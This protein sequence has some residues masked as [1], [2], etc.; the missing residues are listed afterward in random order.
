MHLE[1]LSKTN[2]TAEA[3]LSGVLA[4][5]VRARQFSLA[6]GLRIL[7]FCC[8]YALPVLF[9][10]SAD[11]NAQSN[12][13][14]AAINGYVVDQAGNALRGA[15][16]VA[17]NLA[18]GVADETLSDANGYYR[19]PILKIGKY[20]VKV[21]ADGFADLVKSAV[22]LEVGAE[23]RIDAAL[24]VG[25]TSTT[26]EVRPD[27]SILETS[28]PAIGAH[29]D[30]N[31]LRVLPITSRNIYNYEF[32][33]PGVVGY[34]KST[35]SAPHPAYN[36]ITSSTL[37]LDGIDNTQRNA[38]PDIRLVISTPEVV[39]QSQT[40]VNGA[41][42]EFGRTAGGISNIVSRSGGNEYHGQVLA[43]LRPNATRAVNALITGGKPSSKW[44]DYDGNVGGPILRN[45]LFFFANFEYNSLVN[46]DSIAITAADAAVLKIPSSEL[47]YAP[48]SERYP[49][50]SVRVDYKVNE[51]NNAFFRWSYFSNHEPNDVGGGY[52]PANTGQYW[53]DQMQSGEA[54]LTTAVTPT[55]LN[56]FRFGVTRR[57]DGDFNMQS[58]VTKDEVITNIT[59]VA[60]FGANYNGNSPA[61][62]R[63]IAIVDNVTKTVGKHTVKAGVDF[64]NTNVQQ[65]SPLTLA[66]TFADLASYEKTIGGICNC[67]QEAM[68]QAG[69][70][71]I[72]NYWNSPNLFVQDEYRANRKLT[73]NAGLRYQLISWPSLDKSAP[74]KDSRSIYTSHLDFAPRLS[75]SY[76]LTP[77]TTLR[78]AGGL[79]FDTPS[80]S[81]FNDISQNNGANIHT[82]VFT[83]G[84][85]SPTYPNVPTS[86]GLL[87]SS[88]PS[89]ATYDPNYR[90]M[91]AIQ[92]NLQVERAI[93]NNLSV[94]LSYQFLATRHSPYGHD[95][96]LAAPLCRLADGRPAYTES[97]CGTGS[98]TS[99]T[100]PNTN[101]GSIVMVS[102]GAT[103]NYNGLHATIKQRLSRGIQFEATYSWSKT[104]GTADQVNDS[105]GSPIEDPTNIAREYGPQS[106]DMRHNFVLQGFFSP[107]TTIKGL[108]WM[109]NFNLSTMT[110]LHS[111]SPIN[112]YAG[113][114][115][116][117]DTNLN[118]RPLSTRRNSLYGSNLYEE[119]M[120]LTY[121]IPLGERF[122]LKLYSEAENL[123]NHPNLNCDAGYGCSSAVNNDIASAQ[124]LQ[125]TS[126]RNPRGFNFGSMITF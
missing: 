14:D 32:F 71:T 39:E 96:N 80:W 73:L 62:E 106:S 66:Y 114:D 74:Y 19:F 93:T 47:G 117:G 99:I 45:R 115:L 58:N 57:Y 59:N 120:R 9:C 70:P 77:A 27:A 21:K 98:D 55:F 75:A 11:G 10:A 29:I 82:Y 104:L 30:A 67:Y 28:T 83:P 89:L 84:P 64:E 1:G 20:E 105:T 108:S 2:N 24:S 44:Q 52:I 38:I 25:S 92:A 63:N 112:V 46:P 48:N 4:R 12:A 103:M 3:A 8:L 118:D 119:D 56:E 78:A 97:A 65:T 33:S 35:F 53:E 95:I 102:S 85:A 81:I 61:T 76:L 31:A 87:T 43:A 111:G 100:R 41:T 109:S 54:Q 34:P 88:V 26:I 49:T 90:D 51:K 69:N 124:F 101:F 68:F 42:A 72:S 123:F 23:V 16:V 22:T 107:V 125:P 18:T 5:R 79:Y 110:Y 37:L 113:S 7:G 36:G 122:R 13:T 116:N 86:A 91:Y 6:S 126:D 40:I 121:Q 15:H 50:P 94:D 60:Q 17:R